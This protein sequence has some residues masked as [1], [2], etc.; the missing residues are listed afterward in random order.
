LKREPKSPST[1]SKETLDNGAM[2]R[3]LERFADAEDLYSQLDEADK[4][5]HE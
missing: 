4:K 5:A 3:K 2:E 1:A